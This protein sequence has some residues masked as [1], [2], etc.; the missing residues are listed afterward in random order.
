MK[1]VLVPDEIGN[2]SV[3]VVTFE[4]V[5]EQ[6]DDVVVVGVARKGQLAAVLHEFFELRRV[7]EAELVK[8]HLLLLALNGIILLVLGATWEA[9]PRQRASEEVEQHVTNSLEVISAGL[10]VTDVRANGRVS[11][12]TS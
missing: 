4:T 2:A 5:L 6:V 1:P 10:L 3:E 8:G 11:S 9:L 7:V 12:G